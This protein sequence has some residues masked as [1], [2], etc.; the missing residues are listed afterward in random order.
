MK[1]IKLFGASL[2]MALTIVC[3]TVSAQVKKDFHITG[4]VVDSKTGEHLAGATVLILDTNYGAISD[5]TGHY[6]ITG[7]AQGHYEVEASYNGYKTSVKELV[8]GEKQTIGL[9]FELEINPI[10][11]DDI[12]VSSTRNETKKKDSPVLVGVVSSDMLSVT[13]SVNAA[14]GLNFQPGLR[15]EYNCNNC[16]VPQLRINGLEGQYSQLLLDSRPLHSSLASVYGLEQLPSG[17]IERIEIIRGG[18]SALYGSN[19]IAGVVNIIT[20]EPVTNT[21]SIGN[22][23]SVMGGSAMDYNTTLNGSIITPDNKFGLYLFSVLRERESYD[24]NDD[25]FSEIP[26]LNSKTVGLRSFYRFSNNSKITLEYHNISE[27]RR[28][29]DMLDRPAHEANIAEQLTHNINGG[30]LRYDYLSPNKKNKF[31]IY[32]SAQ[33]IN[34]DSYFGTEQNL[35]AYGKSDDV[36]ALIGGQYTLFADRVLFMPADFTVG[37]EYNYNKL[38]DEMLG[39]DRLIEQRSQI[40]GLFVQNEWKIDEFS[41]LLG[42]RLDK[43]NL[44]DGAILSPRAN[45]RY[46]PTENIILRASYSSG[47][48]APQAYDEDLHVAAV[49]GE[50]SLVVLDP[51]LKPEYSNSLSASADFYHT[52]GKTSMNFLVEGFYTK[53]KDVF[54]LEDIGEDSYGNMLLERRNAD[55]MTV[56]GVNL[57]GRLN[58]NHKL[59]LQAGFTYQHGSYDSAVNWSDDEEVEATTELL[60]TPDTYGY[61]SLAWNMTDKWLLSANGIYT[62]SMYAPHYYEDDVDVLTKTNSFWDMGLKLSY[63]TKISQYTDMEIS[64]GVKNIFDSYQSDLDKGIEKDA[65]YIYGPYLPRTFYL[66]VKFSL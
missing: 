36:T 58:Y 66:G 25:T 14:E 8:V 38:S 63:T 28:G 11:F 46:T 7:L 15:V 5:A 62:G 22:T 61:I 35:D 19:A 3:T 12:V 45:V 30:G 10:G 13:S 64:G 41:L 21:F 55:G 17:M 31:S 48:R 6:M 4:H 37:A 60:R 65:G 39:Y 34:R 16:G 24:R 56:A 33:K 53:V 27:F 43:H 51:D 50:V 49:G 44:V 2:L 20:K 42:A 40:A 57:E 18:G 32:S 29:G 23:T 9:N 54:V 26:E 47:Y 52:V 59:N 1:N